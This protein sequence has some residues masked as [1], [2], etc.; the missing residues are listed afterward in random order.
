MGRLTTGRNDKM[1]KG[2]LFIRHISNDGS[3]I[4]IHHSIIIRYS[5]H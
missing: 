1:P 3:I 4:H 5:M 2:K